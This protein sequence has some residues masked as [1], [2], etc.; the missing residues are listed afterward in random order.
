[1]KIVSDKRE[2]DKIF[3]RRDRYEI[4]DWQRE[5]VW[6]EERKRVLI[7]SILRGWRLPKFYFAVTGTNPKTYEVVDGQQRLNTIFDFLDD[8]LE[9]SDQTAVEFGGKTYS[10]LPPEVSD[11]V[12]D[13]EIDFDE[14]DDATDEEIVEFFQRLQS[15]IQLNSTEKLN[16]I[17]SNLRDFCRKMASHDFFTSKVSFANKR[18]AHFDVMTKVATIEVEGMS[19]GLRYADLKVTLENQSKFSE[20]SAVAKRIRAALDFLNACMPAKA[21]FLRSR[22]ITQSYINLA[23]AL[24]ENTFFANYGN[25]FRAFI[26]HFSESLAKEGEKGQQGT[27][28]GY[29]DF[30]RS[31]N[32]NVKSGAATRH[33]VLMRKLLKF[34]PS[35]LDEAPAIVIGQS[36]LKEEIGNISADIRSI[37]F[38]LNQYHS[39]KTGEDFFKISNKTSSSLSSLGNYISDKQ[40][41]ANFVDDL[42]YVFYEGPGSRLSAM[43]QVFLDVKQLR[44]ELSHDLDHGSEKDAQKKKVKIGSIFKKYSG[45]TAPDL[46][47]EPAFLLAQHGLLEAIRDELRGMTV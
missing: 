47:S 46:A 14:I 38:K 31:I 20:T 7:D 27:D 8:Q 25:K 13:F 34:D 42:Y 28:A 43:P 3:K 18:Y 22:A 6:D 35:I 40:T 32:A 37:I 45:S 5:I 4:P 1:M 19:A 26:L 30:L 11:L 12:D 29:R 39:S 41:Y 2:L 23:C 17:K 24:A 21:P 16:A 9:L 36:S 33:K 10:E 44:T 15:G